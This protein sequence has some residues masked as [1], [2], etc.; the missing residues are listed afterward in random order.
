MLCTRQKSFHCPSTLA[1]PRSVKRLS[2]LLWRRLAN[3]GSTVA[4]RRHTRSALGAVDAPLHPLGVR[5]SCLAILPMKNATCRVLVLSRRAQAVVA[6]RTRPAVALRAAELDRRRSRR[7]CT[8]ARCRTATCPA[9]HTQVCASRSKVKSSARTAVTLSFAPALLSCSGSGSCL[10]LGPGRRSARRAAHVV[11]G[12]QRL[13]DS[14]RRAAAGS[15]R[16][17]S[18]HRP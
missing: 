8:R 1:C 17:G 13:D 2:R 9:G 15:L 14:S 7:S 16:C 11:V 18:R 6:L 4:K 10:V 3:T 12:D 5:R